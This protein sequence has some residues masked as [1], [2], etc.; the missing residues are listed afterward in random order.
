MVSIKRFHLIIIELKLRNF[1]F[2]TILVHMISNNYLFI[3]D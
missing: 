3:Y 2:Y 1:L